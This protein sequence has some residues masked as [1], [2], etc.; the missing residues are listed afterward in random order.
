MNPGP[1]GQ[2]PIFVPPKNGG[3]RGFSGWLPFTNHKKAAP[4]DLGVGQNRYPKNN[5]GKWTQGLK[6]AVPR[7]F[8]LTQICVLQPDGS[9]VANADGN[10]WGMSGGFVPRKNK[11]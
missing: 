3:F 9:D 1:A 2:A 6:P 5:P 7:G 4:R 10:E 11:V 8:I